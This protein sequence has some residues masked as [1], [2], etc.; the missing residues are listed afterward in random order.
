M[1]VELEYFKFVNTASDYY[2][3]NWVLIFL[4]ISV[5]RFSRGTM[6]WSQ[7]QG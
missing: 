3:F 5:C 2:S 6:V 7:T 1:D 4:Y